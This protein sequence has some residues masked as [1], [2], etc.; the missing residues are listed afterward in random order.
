MTKKDSETR[1]FNDKDKRRYAVRNMN[2]EEH[3]QHMQT[4]MYEGMN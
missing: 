3:R 2:I 4:V 1:K